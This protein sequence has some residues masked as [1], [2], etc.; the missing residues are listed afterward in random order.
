MGEQTPISQGIM[1]VGF[2]IVAVQAFVL[3]LILH[4]YSEGAR[5]QFAVPAETA[6]VDVLAV[7]NLRPLHELDSG[8][9]TFVEEWRDKIE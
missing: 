6:G 8:K 4:T 2:G 7:E 1:E 5:P 9:E 3:R